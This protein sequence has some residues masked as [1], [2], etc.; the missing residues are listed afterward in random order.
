MKYLITFLTIPITVGLMGLSYSAFPPME[1]DRYW[2]CH[3][4]GNNICGPAAPWH[5]FPNLFWNEGK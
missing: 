3:L 5:G 1:D 2:N 4:S